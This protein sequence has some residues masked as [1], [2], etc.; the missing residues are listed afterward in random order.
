MAAPPASGVDGAVV[1]GTD[2]RVVEEEDLSVGHTAN[3]EVRA[4]P[5]RARS[6]PST[7]AVGDQ[8]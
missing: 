8:P 3:P 5:D 1:E 4:E 7:T 6:S 2:F